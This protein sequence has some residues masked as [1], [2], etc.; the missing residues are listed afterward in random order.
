MAFAKPP[1]AEISP[2]LGDESGTRAAVPVTVDAVEYALVNKYMYT[3]AL[4][5]RQLICEQKSR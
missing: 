1:L 5:A 4:I 2:P 3:C